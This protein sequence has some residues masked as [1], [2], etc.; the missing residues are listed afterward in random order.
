MA[1]YPE[2]ARYVDKNGFLYQPLSLNDDQSVELFEKIAMYGNANTAMVTKEVSIGKFRRLAIYLDGDEN[3]DK[4]TPASDGHLRS[5]LYESYWEKNL[6]RSLFTHFTL[7][8]DLKF[9][10][11][12]QSLDRVKLGI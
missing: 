7:L 12:M 9:E 10:G 11:V 6:V 5:L 8:R 1:S 2:V 3:V 4:Y